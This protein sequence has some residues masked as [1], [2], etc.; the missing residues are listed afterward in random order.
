MPKHT[1]VPSVC[2]QVV[3]AMLHRPN[4]SLVLGAPVILVQNPGWL[5]IIGDYT[6]QYIGDYNNPRG[7]SL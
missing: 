6:T 2:A 1:P 5:M 7:E 3:A 4:V